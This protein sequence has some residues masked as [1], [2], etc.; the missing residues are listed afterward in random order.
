MVA[1]PPFLFASPHVANRSFKTVD[2]IHLW[3]LTPPS[4][5][6]SQYFGFQEFNSHDLSPVFQK[7]LCIAPHF[8]K[9]CFASFSRSEVCQKMSKRRYMPAYRRKR[10]DLQMYGRLRGWFLWRYVPPY[11]PI[12]VTFAKLLLC[13][14]GVTSFRSWLP[15][16]LCK[17]AWGLIRVYTCIGFVHF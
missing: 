16:V 5:S 3:S 2:Q 8:I 4:L 13:S 6:R 1:A 12:P 9:V 7:W 17:C 11:Y 10:A 14:L 15:W